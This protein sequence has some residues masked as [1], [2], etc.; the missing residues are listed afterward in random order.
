MYRAAIASKSVLTW[1]QA[2]TPH[3]IR[4]LLVT[5][6]VVVMPAPTLV[7]ATLG[8]VMSAEAEV[9]VEVTLETMAAECK[10]HLA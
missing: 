7:L 1:K 8:A 10:Q 9:E 2:A 4:L 6:G 5:A 3:G